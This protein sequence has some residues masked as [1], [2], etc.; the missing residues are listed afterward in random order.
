MTQRTN[1]W[2][3]ITAFVAGIASA[4]TGIVLWLAPSGGYRG[5]R[6]PAAYAGTLAVDHQLWRDVHV[7]TSLALAALVV[8]HLVAHS[9][10]IRKL[11]KILGHA[12]KRRAAAHEPVCQE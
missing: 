8:V 9:C 3:N 11:P 4:V 5:G 7:W 6:G 12:R 1:A 2:V 10:W